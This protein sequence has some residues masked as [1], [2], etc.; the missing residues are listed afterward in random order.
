MYSII[1]CSGAV[2]CI[3]LI[4]HSPSAT[5]FQALTHVFCI[6]PPLA[7]SMVLTDETSSKPIGLSVESIA[8]IPLAQAETRIMLVA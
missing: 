1:S 2:G 5:C 7:V 4:C 3:L 8:N 6:I